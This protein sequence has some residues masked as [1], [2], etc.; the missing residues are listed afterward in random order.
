MGKKIYFQDIVDYEI[1]GTS[2]DESTLKNL[3][4]QSG[5]ESSNVVNGI[6]KV[7][8]FLIK[9]S[10]PITISGGVQFQVP[11]QVLQISI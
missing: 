6:Y 1:P 11:P 4:S 5:A 3:L 9:K 2:S 8:R 10:Q 7:L